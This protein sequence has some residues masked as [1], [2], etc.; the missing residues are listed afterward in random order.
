[1]V[2]VADKSPDFQRFVVPDRDSWFNNNLHIGEIRQR[3]HWRINDG[4]VP[5]MLR[6]NAPISTKKRFATSDE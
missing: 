3:I 4:Q 1:M 2:V 5:Q 6:N